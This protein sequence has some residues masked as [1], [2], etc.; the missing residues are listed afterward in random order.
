MGGGR[1]TTPRR[2]TRRAL[3]FGLAALVLVVGLVVGGAWVFQRHFVYHPDTRTPPPAAEV[4]PGAS[5]VVLS[6]ADGL[7]L[8]AWWV[9]PSG[10][11]RDQAVLVAPGN[12]GNREGRAR[13][14]ALLAERGFAVLLLDYRGFGGNPGR[15]TEQGLALD[16]HAGQAALVARGYP[17]GR[18]LYFGES[19]GTGVVARLQS[20]VP[21]A[22]V[23]L[24]SPFTSLVDA[25]SHQVP[26][27]P[28]GVL[29]RDRFPVA[30][31]LEHSDVPVT[32]VYGTRDG[33]VPPAQSAEVARAARRLVE[34][35]VIDGAGHND[36][37]MSGPTVVDAVVRL[38]DRVR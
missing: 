36:P 28:V 12:A 34:T 9:P 25:A 30:E 13:F 22:G 16:V 17:P 7:T 19:L 11:A 6:T 10:T 35:V 27:L 20:D 33:V 4:I 15:P 26:L 31:L 38:A 8:T 23:V 3:A 37:V 29:L 1:A 18:T 14:A 24:R 21:P 5:D 32:V 2:R